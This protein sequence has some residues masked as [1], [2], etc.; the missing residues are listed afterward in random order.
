M[1]L[2]YKGVCRHRRGV[3]AKVAVVSCCLLLSSA[4]SPEAIAESAACTPDHYRAGAHNTFTMDDDDMNGVKA[5]VEIP[6]LYNFRN[7]DAWPDFSASDLY[8]RYDYD[9]VQFGWNYG[10]TDASHGFA[11]V[12]RPFIGES[13]E[14]ATDE[15]LQ[16]DWT[17]TLT[18]GTAHLFEL[19]RNESSTSPDYQ[20]FFGFLDG[21]AILKT[22]GQHYIGF[23]GTTGEVNRR[24]HGLRNSVVDERPDHTLAPT[25]KYRRI[26]TNAWYQ[27]GVQ[28]DESNDT[29]LTAT[30]YTTATANDYT[31]FAP[32][33]PQS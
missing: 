14:D 32:S 12:V 9:F 8:G 5:I 2:H 16:Y 20:K 1:A 18:P 33:C 4:S 29:C 6:L 22:R 7:V 21:V 19:R 30:R 26:S 15:I 24:C 13:N 17:R 11:P 25:L 23:T 10:S 31:T 28:F 27:W 3:A